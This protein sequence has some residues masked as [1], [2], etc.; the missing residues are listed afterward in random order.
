ME[1]Q[2]LEQ[3]RPY[4]MESP[5]RVFYRHI[6]REGEK[7]F[8]KTFGEEI[9]YEEV[10]EEFKRIDSL[11]EIVSTQVKEP[12]FP[13]ITL[14]IAIIVDIL[15][16]V[17]FTGFGYFIMLIVN[18]IFSAIL[19]FLMFGKLNVMFTSV[20]KAAFR[21]KRK[22]GSRKRKNSFA[23]GKLNNVAK[24]YLK[25]YMSRR[26]VAII[27]VNFIPLVNILA[28]NA[29]FVILAHNKQKKIAQKYIALIEMVGKIL[30]RQKR[31]R[32]REE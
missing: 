24:K 21:G 8:K 15:D 25:K 5:R 10:K 32:G 13:Y 26:M 22:D 16:V 7:I 28:S 31:R 4:R 11:E 12:H 17:Q 23:Q 2:T 19:F 20:S 14:Y 6:E 30:E 3:E 9:K 18:F 1:D 27:I 29:F